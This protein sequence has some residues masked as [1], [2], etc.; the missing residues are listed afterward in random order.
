[1]STPDNLTILDQDTANRYFIIG[2]GN[3][4]LLQGFPHKHRFFLYRVVHLFLL[5]FSF[6]VHYT[7]GSLRLTKKAADWA[8]L[9]GDYYE[10][11]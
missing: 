4:R 8:T 2:E 9:M 6:F 3:L 7:I 11:V 5:P 1:M 10:K